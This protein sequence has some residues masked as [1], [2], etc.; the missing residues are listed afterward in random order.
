VPIRDIR[1]QRKK[2]KATNT[3]TKLTITAVYTNLP[4]QTRGS[5]EPS[6]P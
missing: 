1:G 6:L 2:R 3:R 4:D 5:A